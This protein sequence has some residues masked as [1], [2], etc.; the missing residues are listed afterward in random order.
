M[1]NKFT[2]T[3]LVMGLALIIPMI[4]VSCVS[5][6][7]F[8]SL[9]EQRNDL[10]EQLISRQQAYEEVESKLEETQSKLTAKEVELFGA[11]QQARTAK[12][13]LRYL[14]NSNTLLLDRLGDL[15]VVSKTGVESIKKSL[16]ALEE[17]NEYIRELTSSLRR[18]DSV[19]LMLVMNLKRSL[20]NFDDEDVTIEVKKGVVYVSLSDKLLFR[21]GSSEITLRAQEVLGK[22]A[23]VVN[24]HKDLDLLVEGHTDNVDIG[25]NL[26]GIKDNWDLSTQR[27][28][29]VV[30]VL[31]NQFQVNPAR[32]TAAG[33][34][35]YLPKTTNATVEGRGF[36]RRTEIIILPKLDE[37]FKLLEPQM[38]GKITTN[39]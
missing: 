9:E 33:R 39:N 10:N 1:K 34:S 8:T 27:A 12:E 22:I 16:E 20:N 7:K 6:K 28:I 24:D 11:Q 17:R 3:K 19:N 18:T 31:Q 14:R 23:S 36:N 2:N 26:I 37:F 38:T 35:K 25:K 13:D 15:S 5:N 4:M 29:S 21:S 30:R 32:L